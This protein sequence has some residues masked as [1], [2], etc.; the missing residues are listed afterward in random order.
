MHLLW[1]PLL[2]G[3]LA[4]PDIAGCELGA[5]VLAGFKEGGLAVKGM[6]GGEL[7]AHTRLPALRRFGSRCGGHEWPRT[8]CVRARPLQ[9]SGSRRTGE[10]H[11]DGA[12][13]R[14]R[15]IRERPR[16]SGQQTHVGVSQEPSSPGQELRSLTTQTESAP[17]SQPRACARIPHPFRRSQEGLCCAC[18]GGSCRW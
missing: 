2:H 12:R 4:M 15:G 14:F 11:Y 1:F 10:R 16:S 13:V 7:G 6:G 9:R 17:P 5:H 18:P 8:R 3:D